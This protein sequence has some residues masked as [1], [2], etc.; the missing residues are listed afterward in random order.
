MESSTPREF[1]AGIGLL[2]DPVRRRLYDFVA[3]QVDP[4]AREE[5]AMGAKTSRTLAAYHLDK[6]A[7]AGLLEIS[8]SRHNGRTGPGS[9]RPAKRYTRAQRE[10]SAS[11]PPRNYSLLAQILA[12]AADTSDE[13]RAALANAAAQ[14]GE[15]LGAQAGDLPAALTAA[16]YE[17]SSTDDGDIILRNCPF[18]Q[19]MQQHTQLVCNLNHAFIE[20]ALVGAGSDPA[21]AEL[22]PCDGRCCVVIHPEKLPR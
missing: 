9:G 20:G 21:R 4:V 12:D 10:T 8:Y 7:E 16:G 5:A 6:L 19:V 15:T 13:T 22:S 14:Q 3:E 1:V 11:F 18:H 17:P 2:V